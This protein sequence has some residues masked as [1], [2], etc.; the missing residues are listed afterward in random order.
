MKMFLKYLRALT[1]N[2]KGQDMV[3]YGLMISLV[4]VAFIAALIVLGPKITDLFA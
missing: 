1:G 2:E 4:A 3:E